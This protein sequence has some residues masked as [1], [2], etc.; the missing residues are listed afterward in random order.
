MQRAKRSACNAERAAPGQDPRCI[1]IHVFISCNPG[2]VIVQ[3][4]G[5]AGRE[6]GAHAVLEPVSEP[7][8]IDDQVS[9]AIADPNSTGPL[10]DSPWACSMA[11]LRSAE[12]HLE[13]ALASQSDWRALQQLQ[14]REDAGE[15]FDVI[16]SDLLRER[17]T[18]S[19]AAEPAFMAW[20]FVDAALACLAAGEHAASTARRDAS[21]WRHV[22]V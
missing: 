5:S 20:Q 14:A 6:C 21:G 22:D 9:F 8:L 10:L 13:A 4:L 19:L 3:R 18:L 16:E 17:L 1:N 15:W 7:A 12:A 11:A 2:N